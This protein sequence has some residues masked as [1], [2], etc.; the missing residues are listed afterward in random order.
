MQCSV[1]RMQNMWN[2]RFVLLQFSSFH[3]IQFF[4]TRTN[5]NLIPMPSKLLSRVR[6]HE[7]VR[8]RRNKSTPPPPV[9]RCRAHSVSPAGFDPLIKFKTAPRMQNISTETL[10]WIHPSPFPMECTISFVSYGLSHIAA[11]NVKQPNRANKKTYPSARY[12]VFSEAKLS[13]ILL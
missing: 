2:V 4:K 10:R 6:K 8:G 3:S 5:K 12:S 13:H 1:P 11:E 9:H 7:N